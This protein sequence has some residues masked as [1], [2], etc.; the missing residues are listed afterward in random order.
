MSNTLLSDSKN[1][2]YNTSIKII[3]VFVFYN[4]LVAALL[5]YHELWE[6]EWLG[7]QIGLDLSSFSVFLENMR[8]NGHPFIWYLLCKFAWTI[9]P[10][11][12][13]IKILHWCITLLTSYILLFRVRVSLL[14]KIFFLFSYFMMFEY[15]VVL[16]NYSI[17][18]LFVLLCLSEIQKEERKNYFIILF[19]VAGMVLTHAYGLMLS[20]GFL[21]YLF[22]DKITYPKLWFSD[23]SF[24]MLLA[25]YIGSAILM[26]YCVHPDKKTYF[27]PENH[28]QLVNLFLQSPKA[29][30][31]IWN[32]I[33]N[34]PLPIVGFRNSNIIDGIIRNLCSDYLQ[35]EKKTRIAI[36]ITKAILVLPVLYGIYKYFKPEKKIL[37]TL[38][39]I[40]GSIFIF[41]IEIF[42]GLIRHNGFYLVSL[43]MVVCLSENINKRFIEGLM[44]LQLICAFFAVYMEFGHDFSGSKSCADYINTHF[45]TKQNIAIE[46]DNPPYFNAIKG[47]LN[48]GSNTYINGIFQKKNYVEWQNLDPDE[49]YND[50]NFD[51]Q[52]KILSKLTSDQKALVLCYNP[53][54]NHK[55]ELDSLTKAGMKFYKFDN[56]ISTEDFYLLTSKN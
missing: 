55:K 4:L 34:I 38:L 50:K 49:V 46:I 36:Y 13:S 3:L 12:N 51:T 56:T 8:M 21:F 31:N 39:F 26:I 14:M 30:A 41:Q 22:Y 6:D 54:I 2:K 29:L 7:I 5:S 11:L 23:K 16:R 37:F 47:Y 27:Y 53:E 40:W 17:E 15:A 35:D 28:S 9:Y 52:I 24:N 1:T 45:N 48:A 32:A 43:F 33:I 20:G 18:V 25:G 44:A 42:W 10:S 19:C